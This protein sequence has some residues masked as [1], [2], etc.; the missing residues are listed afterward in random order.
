MCLINILLKHFSIVRPSRIQFQGTLE[1]ILHANIVEKEGHLLS[2]DELIQRL[3]TYDS[4][5]GI[6]TR[7]LLIEVSKLSGKTICYKGKQKR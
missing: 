1:E 7:E 5:K 6:G 2:V 3:R 4:L